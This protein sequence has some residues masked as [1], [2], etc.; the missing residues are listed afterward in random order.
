MSS[1][2]GICGPIKG[3]QDQLEILQRIYDQHKGDYEKGR[4]DGIWE[5]ERLTGKVAV[6][7]DEERMEAFGILTMES[8]FAIWSYERIKKAYDAWRAEKR[9]EEKEE[10]DCHN[11]AC[12]V[13]YEREDGEITWLCI[14]NQPEKSVRVTL[15][16]LCCEHWKA[17][18]EN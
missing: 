16:N 18:G 7:T 2:K 17:R 12:S 1:N 15:P 14:K 13:W 4:R 10:A 11:C 5:M 9:K 3:V 8:I 6:M